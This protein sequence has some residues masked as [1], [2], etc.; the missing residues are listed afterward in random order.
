[1]RARFK[2]GLSERVLGGRFCKAFGLSFVLEYNE[3]LESPFT[4][5]DDPSVLA[6]TGYKRRKDDGMIHGT[7]GNTSSR[8][9]R[10][11]GNTL[12]SK[13]PQQPATDVLERPV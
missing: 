9:G 10:I 11:H 13:Q 12:K 4:C 6:L 5:V 8:D 2:V 1:M 3:G 7:I